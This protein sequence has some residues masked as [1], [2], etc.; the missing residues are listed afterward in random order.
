M[1][2]AYGIQLTRW[3]YKLFLR[4]SR[5]LENEETVLQNSKYMFSRLSTMFQNLVIN[6]DKLEN[7]RVNCP[8]KSICNIEAAAKYV[9][10]FN[11]V[12]NAIMKHGDSLFV[13]VHKTAI[14]INCTR[15]LT[16]IVPIVSIQGSRCKRKELS[17]NTSCQGPGRILCAIY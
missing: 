6:L 11:L 14:H 15:S 2:T 9:R 7:S 12:R 17:L 5:T 1:K 16:T 10:S 3:L 4:G 13:H 8:I